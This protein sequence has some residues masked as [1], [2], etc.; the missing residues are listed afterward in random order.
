ME[1]SDKIIEILNKDEKAKTLRSSFYQAVDTHG[2]DFSDEELSEAIELMTMLAI[3]QNEEAMS[4]MA[5][6]VYNELRNK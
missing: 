4:L 1:Y 5:E 6:T 3:R 2:R